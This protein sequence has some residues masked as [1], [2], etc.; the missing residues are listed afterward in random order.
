MREITITTPP[1]RSGAEG[2]FSAVT[3]CRFYLDVP[4]HPGAVPHARCCIRSTLAAWQLGA[5][6][7]DTELIVSNC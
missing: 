7:D 1:V 6:A 2:A 4:A 3:S 5:I